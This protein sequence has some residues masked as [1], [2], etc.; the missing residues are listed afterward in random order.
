M[1]K[2]LLALFAAII[3]SSLCSAQ[4]DTL[5]IGGPDG[6][7]TTQYN[8]PFANITGQ[9]GKTQYIF[10]QTELETGGLSPAYPIMGACFSVVDNDLTDP[11]CLMDLHLGLKNTYQQSN[12]PLDEFNVGIVSL[13]DATNITLSEGLLCLSSPGTPYFQWLSSMNVLVE[14]AF[15]RGPSPGIS[16][17]VLLRTDLP[18]LRTRSATVD[19]PFSGTD[20][21]NDTPGVDIGYD[22]SVPV[23]GFLVDAPT[24]TR[25][26][27]DAEQVQCYPNP[28]KTSLI[29]RTP[30]GTRSVLI[31][32]V[33]GRLVLQLPVQSATVQVDVSAL[34]GGCYSVDLFSAEGRTA[35]GTFIKG[36][37]GL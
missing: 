19:Y 33:C 31:T 20:I 3:P 14:V 18:E 15:E 30:Q 8:T 13:A 37:P 12:E 29:V 35:S 28:A 22:N 25:E 16:P 9:A 1:H 27:V 34:P 11:A 21:M 26:N 10:H 5:W 32:D 36:Q 2:P 24:G 4:Y 7:S 17:R 6:M 23:V